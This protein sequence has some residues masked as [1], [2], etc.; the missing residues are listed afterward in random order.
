MRLRI[1]TRLF[2]GFTVLSTI[3]V[4]SS[5]YL[6]YSQTSKALL[7]RLQE[8]NQ[9]KLYRYQ[10]ALDNMIEDMDRISAQVIYSSAIK[11]Y[12]IEQADEE[13]SS[14]QSFIQR[15]QY[16]NMLA[17]LNGPWFIAAQINLITLDGFFLTYG[18]DMNPVPDIKSKIKQSKWLNQAFELDG[19]KLLVPPHKS[20]WQENHPLYFS[21]VR[22]FNL[23]SALPAAA[24]EIQ[25]PYEL[26]AQSV[27]IDRNEVSKSQV[28]IVNDDGELFYPD[29]SEGSVRPKVPRWE[30]GVKEVVN[31]SGE[32][33]L[34]SRQRS[35]F[36]GLTV[37]IQQS[38]SEV[39]QPIADLRRITLTLGLLG[40]CVSLVIAYILSVGISS[41]I[42]YLQKRLEKVTLDHTITPSII[43]KLQNT[44]EIGMLYAT[45]EDMTIR[46]NHSLNELIQAQKRESAAHV[47]A[48]YAQMDPH[49][50]YNTLT[51]MASYAEESGFPEFSRIAQQL[52]GMM[53][54]STNS[55]ANAVTLK[56]E[57][58]YTIRYMEL[59]RFRYEGQ[60][61]FT[62][63]VEPHLE[64]INVPKF[65]LQPLVENSFAHGFQQARPPW[66]IEIYATQRDES[67]AWEILIRDNGS[68]FS[69]Q[70]LTETQALI[71]ELNTGQIR[72]LDHLS[73]HGIGHMGIINT[74]TRCRLFWNDEVLFSLRNLSHGMEFIIKVKGD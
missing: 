23:P 46:L 14:Y 19:E 58:Q 51:A 64:D 27:E 67:Q 31:E 49:F 18:K 28:Y 1:H 33:E 39:M 40:E 54:Y 56:Q 69:E 9:Q 3:L 32:T 62:V 42:R 48:M 55:M 72:Q 4:L 26:L 71:E 57:V 73:G 5:S 52:S 35:D 30:S 65:L 20:Q 61:T 66:V 24:V 8:T 68:G 74:L 41:P 53:R 2:I 70:S 63:Q 38:K 47:Q 29:F 7:I 17:S 34:W 59:M 37:L 12:I 36:S 50:L 10:E 22:S 16:E 21:L 60:F 25:Q 11:N 6:Y 45:Y 15:E 13:N 43:K 44:K